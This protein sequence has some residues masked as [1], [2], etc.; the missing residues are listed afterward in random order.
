[1]KSLMV[2]S[3]RS[4]R[5][6]PKSLRERTP[7]RAS[8]VSRKVLLGIVPVLMPAPPTSW[9]FSTS[10]TRL[11]KIPAVFAPLIPAGPPPTTTRSK[12]LV[13]DARHRSELWPNSIPSFFYRR[14]GGRIPK[15]N[16]HLKAAMHLLV[17][18]PLVRGRRTRDR[19]GLPVEEDRK[20]REHERDRNRFLMAVHFARRTGQRGWAWHSGQR[21]TMGQE[22][23]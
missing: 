10:A 6:T 22:R 18:R 8:A 13:I 2:A 5:S 14:R 20:K 7:E 16:Y 3:R 1:M 21:K 12:S 23:I 9:S 17:Q 11:P 19:C 4:E 15:P